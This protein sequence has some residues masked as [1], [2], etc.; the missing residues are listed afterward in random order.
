MSEAIILANDFRKNGK[1]TE[2]V[3]RRNDVSVETYMEHAKKNLCISMMY[4][5]NT[6][7]I[8]MINLVTGARKVMTSKIK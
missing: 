7:E 5:K 2:M 1:V 8:E 4:L 3:K 6:N